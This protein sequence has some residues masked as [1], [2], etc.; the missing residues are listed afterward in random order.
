MASYSEGHVTHS[1]IA[2]A[3]MD[4]PAARMATQLAHPTA[5]IYCM[6][7]TCHDWKMLGRVDYDKWTLHDDDPIKKHT[8]DWKAVE[9]PENRIGLSRNMV[10]NTWSFGVSPIGLAV[11]PLPLDDSQTKS[12]GLSYSHCIR[13]SYC[14][15]VCTIIHRINIIIF[16]SQ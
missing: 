7:C 14:V 8:L 16:C 1:A 9:S 4:L 5:H 10:P 15:K 3:A 2:V 13:H 12:H 11:I 6:V